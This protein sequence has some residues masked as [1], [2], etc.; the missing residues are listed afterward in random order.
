MTAP[1]A[2]SAQPAP[3][4]ETDRQA[5]RPRG[6]LWTNLVILCLLLGVAGGLYLVWWTPER[7]PGARPGGEYE[8]YDPNEPRGNLLV[9]KQRMEVLAESMR[10]Y[11]DEFGDSVRWPMSLEDLKFTQLLPADFEF[12]GVLS[13]KP[14]HYAP[15]VPAGFDASRWAICCDV[16]MAWRSNPAGYGSVRAPVAAVVILG[17]GTVRVLQGDE[18]QKIGGLVY[19]QNAPR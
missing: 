14:L 7:E 4:S 8:N 1:D 18:V 15:E 2:Q 16:E 3:P 17:D 11:R 5:P 12:K 19:E 6:Q 9:S 10:R 13:R